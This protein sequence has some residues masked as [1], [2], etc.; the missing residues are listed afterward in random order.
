VTE[1]IS[2]ALGSLGVLSILFA[3]V[4]AL[5]DRRLDHRR[6]AAWEH[7]WTAVAPHWTGRA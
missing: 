6:L 3:A 2:A 7:D 1:T 5:I 4:H